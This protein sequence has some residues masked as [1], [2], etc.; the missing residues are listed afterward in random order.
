MMNYL[1]MFQHFD[2]GFKNNKVNIINL[3]VVFG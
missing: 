2:K 3:G 1:D